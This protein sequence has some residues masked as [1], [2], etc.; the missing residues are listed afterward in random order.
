MIHVCELSFDDGG[1][2]PF[3]AGFLATVSSAYAMERLSFYGAS[4]HIDE[5]KKALKPS[6]AD[7]ITWREIHPPVPGTTYGKRFIREFRIIRGLLEA[8]K[9]DTT[10]RLIFASAYPST[11]LALKIARAFNLKNAPVQIILHGMSGV[12]GKRYRHPIRRFQ[13]MRS[14]LG[15]LANTNIQYLVLEESI[16][17]TV[18]V[19]LPFLSENIEA[20][21]HP[22]APTEGSTEGIPLSKPIR[23]GFLGLADK[24]K[25]FPVF[26]ELAN[27]IMVNH[28][29]DAE[30]HVVGRFP[31]NTAD[32]NGT[33]ALATK[34]GTELMSRT[35][36]AAGLRP[37]HF[38]VLS[39]EAATYALTASGV[40][41]DAI[42]WQKPIIA[43]RIPIFEAMFK[44]YGDIGYLF[45]DDSELRDIV[46]RILA[47]ADTL[48]YQRQASNLQMAR[49]ARDPES[50]TAA[51]R[52][53]CEKA[54]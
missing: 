44:R 5:L 51:Y 18:R 39:H 1:H 36:F 40:V 42:A 33:E 25:G 6:L 45:S 13:D 47:A 48:R 10:T 12:T 50:L 4:T 24:A 15:F 49:K 38:V 41:L 23:F 53:L 22:I 8:L 31:E 16:R 28:K 14:A 2:V 29:K 17:D 9:K 7:S 54:G 52:E 32:M 46:E 27:G 37:L 43:R 11:V 26:L 3:N 19:K 34:P 20:L 21:E 35:K 30:F